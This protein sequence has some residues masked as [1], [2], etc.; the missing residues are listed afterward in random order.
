MS[1]HS[2]TDEI[3]FDTPDLPGFKMTKNDV[4]DSL[5]KRI[6]ELATLNEIGRAIS[7]ATKINQLIQLIY[8]QT[9]RIM[10]V[11]AFYIALY[12]NKNDE[13]QIIF[14]VLHG[15]RQRDEETIRK[16]G[17]GRTEY[18]IRTKEPL[19][20]NKN[21]QQTYKK[22]GIISTDKK[23]KACV[24]VPLIYGN[25]AIGALVVQSYTHNDAYNEGHVSFLT[26]IANQAAIA[27]ENA[28]LFEKLQEELGERRKVEKRLTE[29]NVDLIRAKKD[30]DNILNNVKD[31]LF[32][33][34]KDIKIG[35]QYSAALEKIFEEKS[36][37]GKSILAYMRHKVPKKILTT[38]KDYLSLLFDQSIDGE[39]LQMLN[40]LSQ[41]RMDF[42]L[43]KT[44]LLSK[45]LTFDF[46]RI[47]INDSI[48]DIIVSVNDV[49]EQVTLSRNLEESKEQSKKQMEWLFTIL[50]VDSQMLEEFMTSSEEEFS[51]IRNSID[52]GTVQASIDVI[53]RSI[54]LIK[55]NASMLG[56]DFV[57]E[58]AHS[59]E[60]SLVLLRGN[61]SGKREIQQKLIKQLEEFFAIFNKVQNLIDRIGNFHVQFRPT[62][63]HESNVLFNSISNLIETLGKR[64]NKEIDLDYSEYDSAI[65]PHHHRLLIRDILVQLTRN[66]IYHGIENADERLSRNKDRKGCISISNTVKEQNFYLTF[67]DDGRGLQINNIIKMAIQTGLFKKSEINKWSKK[68]VMDLIFLPGLTTTE[69]TDITAGRGIGMDIIK[70]KVEKNGGSI[71]I[72]SKPDLFSKFTINLPIKKQ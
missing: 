50:N 51:V 17:K 35:T 40:P 34:N 65:V 63:K 22:L 54:H 28:R 14:D 13:M 11:S 7:S 24:G 2:I 46:R 26:T 45:Y 68:R 62:R 29:R 30:T 33:I 36:L 41:I 3:L 56:M 6:E 9:T 69:N 48:S 47:Y 71:L 5:R 27:I 12:D 10:D 53:Y 39:S 64:Y 31:G 18:I 8:K 25:D 1:N 44:K 59:I 38:L 43:T 49:T 67:K 58:Q 32:V 42:N 16:F 19:L 61:K 15:N 55:G 66:S 72:E 23:V 52:K 60:E 20:V 4:E 21:P 37:A 70:S 57:A